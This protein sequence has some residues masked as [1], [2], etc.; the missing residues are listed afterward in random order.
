MM[1]PKV[2]KYWDSKTCKKYRIA[3]IVNVSINTEGYPLMFGDNDL[4]LFMNSSTALS[5]FP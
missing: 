1:A 5:R 4:A 2:Q 3:V